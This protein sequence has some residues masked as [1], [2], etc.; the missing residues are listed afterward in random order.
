M[1]AELKD[2]PGFFERFENLRAA[3]HAKDIIAQI[4]EAAEVRYKDELERLVSYI[5]NPDSKC[6]EIGE[7]NRTLNWLVDSQLAQAQGIKYEKFATYNAEERRISVIIYPDEF[8]ADCAARLMTLA[9]NRM[10]DEVKIAVE[11]TESDLQSCQLRRT[12][13]WIG[14]ILAK[15]G[16]IL[17]GP[18]FFV[19]DDGHIV[20]NDFPHK[21]SIMCAKSL[22]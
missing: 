17:S 13:L 7:D 22:R 18:G 8:I 14:P 11:I 9:S 5:K 16:F 6:H 15:R 19:H 10:L 1:A 20:R 2:E 12:Y 21:W 4:R 3:P